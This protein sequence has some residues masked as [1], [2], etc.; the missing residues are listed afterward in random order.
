MTISV[1]METEKEERAKEGIQHEGTHKSCVLKGNFVQLEKEKD[2][3]SPAELFWSG[4]SKR[5]LA[6]VGRRCLDTWEAIG[7]TGR[8]SPPPTS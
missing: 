5:R 6:D 4:A 7:K 1:V 8:P 2:R 3:E